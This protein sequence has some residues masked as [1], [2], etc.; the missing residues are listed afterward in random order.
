MATITLEQFQQK[1][2]DQHPNA[3]KWADLEPN[4]VHTIVKLRFVDTK[5]GEACIITLNNDRSFWACSGLVKSLK[6]N[7]VMPKHLVS[8]G[9]KQSNKSANMFWSFQLVDA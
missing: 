5:N 3:D 7:D 2:I 9:K 8:L 6:Q 4:Q 1:Y